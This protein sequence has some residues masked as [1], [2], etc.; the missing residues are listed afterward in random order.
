MSP[1]SLVKVKREIIVTELYCNPFHDTNP[2]SPNLSPDMS[3][4]ITISPPS[5]EYSVSIKVQTR[6]IRSIYKKNFNTHEKIYN[7]KKKKIFSQPHKKESPHSAI[8]VYRQFE[9]PR[10]P[11]VYQSPVPRE[12]THTRLHARAA[13]S[14]IRI[15]D[16]S[17][18][19]DSRC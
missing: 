8:Y 1:G 11:R 5:N 16:D 6:G 13:Q 18:S 15:T 14:I 10:R 19:D 7:G 9:F 12:I 2:S 17:T 3:I 4:F